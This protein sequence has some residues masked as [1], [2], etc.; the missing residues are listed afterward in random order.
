VANGEIGRQTD[1][2]VDAPDT[3][4]DAVAQLRAR[5][6][7][8]DVRLVDGTLRWREAGAG[9]TA[10]DALVE[11]IFRFEGDSDPGDEMVVFALRDPESGALGTLAAAFGPAAD[12]E[13]IQ[14]LTLLVGRSHTA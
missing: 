1:A 6:Y 2:M 13:V 14:H 4:T 12:P 11:V 5:G 9:C 10:A 7:T 8:D 3:V